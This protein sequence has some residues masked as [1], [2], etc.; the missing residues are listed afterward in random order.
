MEMFNNFLRFCV[1]F[2]SKGRQNYP[3]TQRIFDKFYTFQKNNGKYL[4]KDKTQEVLNSI[5]DAHDFILNKTDE[6]SMD[7]RENNYI[8]AKTLS[9]T[10]SSNKGHALTEENPLEL[11][12]AA[13]ITTTIILEAT[14]VG[15]LIVALLALVK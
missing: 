6:T 8:S 14:L 2:E 11:N 13:F 12:K 9:L 1:Q 10:N 3:N 15:T 7:Y 4:K 5:I